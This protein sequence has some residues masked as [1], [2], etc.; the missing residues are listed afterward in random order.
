M[1][2]RAVH[3]MPGSVRCGLVRC[4]GVYNRGVHGRWAHRIRRIAQNGG[5]RQA[6]TDKKGNEFLALH[7]YWIHCQYTMGFSGT[8]HACWGGILPQPGQKHR[9]PLFSRIPKPQRLFMAK[10]L[11]DWPKPARQ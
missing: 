6:K 8:I 9:T 3:F 5:Q 10:I 7:T 4:G 11:E 1:G 2:G